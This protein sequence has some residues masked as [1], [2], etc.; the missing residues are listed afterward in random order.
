MKNFLALYRAGAVKRWHTK[1]TIKDQDLAAHSWGVAMILMHIAPDCPKYLIQHALAHD[2]HESEAGD[3]PYPFKRKNPE[4]RRQYTMQAS[5][6]ELDHG[7]PAI[8]CGEDEHLIKWCDMFELLLW[9]LRERLLG[10]T[11]IEHT[12]EVA[13]AA[14]LEMGHPTPIAAELFNEVLNA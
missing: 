1:V 12:L 2:L 11:G 7:I 3:V 8:D 4:V 9:C 14:L 13:T 10:N 5:Q 6:F